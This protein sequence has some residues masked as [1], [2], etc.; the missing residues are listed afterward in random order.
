[1]LFSASDHDEHTLASGQADYQASSNFFAW[2]WSIDQAWNSIGCLSFRRAGCSRTG[3]SEEVVVRASISIVES[4]CSFEAECI[5]S[6]WQMLGIRMTSLS[7]TL[8]TTPSIRP[9]TVKFFLFSLSSLA[10]TCVLFLLGKSDMDVWYYTH[11]AYEDH[12]M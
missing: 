10:L 5:S 4:W 11:C 1:M 9:W 2:I 7:S 3:W 8:A 6:I 12:N